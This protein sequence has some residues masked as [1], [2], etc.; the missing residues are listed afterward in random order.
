MFW[1]LV[2]L[3]V[4]ITLIVAQILSWFLQGAENNRACKNNNC[5]CDEKHV[6]D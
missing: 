5:Q 2:C 3:W 4:G 1:L 6:A